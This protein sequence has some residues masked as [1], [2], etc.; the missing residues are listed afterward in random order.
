MNTRQSHWIYFGVHYKEV[1]DMFFIIEL[2]YGTKTCT[3]AL[4][5]L[6]CSYLSKQKTRRTLHTC[7]LA[8]WPPTTMY[9]CPTYRSHW[10]DPVWTIHWKGLNWLPIKRSCLRKYFIQHDWILTARSSESLCVETK[11]INS[12]YKKSPCSRIWSWLN[13]I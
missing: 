6:C 13:L 12:W 7:C 10:T 9:I 11:T 3:L 2:G 4:I 8:V 5:A 1:T